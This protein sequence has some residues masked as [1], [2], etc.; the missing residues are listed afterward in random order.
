MSGITR[1][2]STVAAHSPECKIDVSVLFQPSG[3]RSGLGLAFLES[4]L[5]LFDM[6]HPTHFLSPFVAEPRYRP[7]RLLEGRHPAADPAMMVFSR[8]DSENI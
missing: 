4:S 5:D 1:A 2:I 6:I 8:Q 7:V 3:S